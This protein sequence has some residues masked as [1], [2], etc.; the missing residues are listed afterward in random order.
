MGA[1]KYIFEIIQK[2]LEGLRGERKH[3]QWKGV[4]HMSM[5][6]SEEGKGGWNSASSGSGSE[7]CV[8]RPGLPQF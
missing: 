2:R 1:T 8:M 6:Y 7:A 5:I 3:Q 4:D